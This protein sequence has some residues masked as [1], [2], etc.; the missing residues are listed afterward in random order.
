MLGG[1][2]AGFVVG[3]AG[4]QVI[5]FVL[6]EIEGLDVFEGLVRNLAAATARFLI[7]WSDKGDTLAVE[8][9]PRLR[10]QTGDGGVVSCYVLDSAGHWVNLV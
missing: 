7:L 3:N 2:E 6:N 10:L 1:G 5:G 9:F 4:L 8:C